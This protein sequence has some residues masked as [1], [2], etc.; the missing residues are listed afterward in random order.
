MISL[1]LCTLYSEHYQNVEDRLVAE[2]PGWLG[3]NQYDNEL[4]P[5]AYYH[6]L[7]PEIYAQAGGN[8]DFLVAAGS[9]CGTMSGTGRFLREQNPDIKLIMADPVG[10]IFFDFWKTGVPGELGKFE[11]EGI[12]K[13]SLPGCADFGLVCTYVVYTYIYTRSVQVCVYSCMDVRL[14]YQYV[15]ALLPPPPGQ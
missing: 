5:L 6:T 15:C 1:S 3:V 12:G 11:V 7:G 14:C 13:D 9:T 10:S 4:N 2:N 8:V